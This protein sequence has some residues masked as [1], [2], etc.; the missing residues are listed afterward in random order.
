MSRPRYKLIDR[1]HGPEDADEDGWRARSAHLRLRSRCGI[2]GGQ[3]D[4]FAAAKPGEQNAILEENGFTPVGDI[5]DTDVPSR[6]LEGSAA[7]GLVADSCCH[8]SGVGLGM[9]RGDTTADA[10]RV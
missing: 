10:A 8:G 5:N 3:I 4:G 7:R 6:D 1:L 9:A 2:D